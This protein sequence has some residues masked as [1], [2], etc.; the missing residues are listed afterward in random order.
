MVY[1]TPFKN[2]LI[3]KGM[4][5]SKHGVDRDPRRTFRTSKIFISEERR[6]YNR[7]LWVSGQRSEG[8]QRST[9][10][11]SC[12]QHQHRYVLSILRIA[13][14]INLNS[15]SANGLDLCYT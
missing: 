8:G 15:R 12:T 13:F 14:A 5:Y 6:H 11:I 4:P 1:W 10:S 3:M 7:Y 2:V 9:V